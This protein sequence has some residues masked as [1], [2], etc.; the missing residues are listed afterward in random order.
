MSE[1]EQ[2]YTDMRAD[3]IRHSKVDRNL[4]M[5]LDKWKPILREF[6]ETKEKEKDNE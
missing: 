1:F 6:I 5:I 4:R 2:L 3:I